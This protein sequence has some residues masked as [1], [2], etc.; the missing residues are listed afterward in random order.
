V[1]PRGGEP[2]VLAEEL[3]PMTGRSRQSSQ[4]PVRECPADGA[5]Q[6]IQ[7]TRGRAVDAASLGKARV[8][9]DDRYLRWSSYG[10]PLAF[11]KQHVSHLLH[12]QLKT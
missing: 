5:A 10:D 6:L 12:P 2:D 9:P 3:A 8:V 4:S 7:L 1:A 11:S